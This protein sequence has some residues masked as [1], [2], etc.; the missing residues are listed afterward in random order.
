M[1]AGYIVLDYEQNDIEYY[2]TEQEAKEALQEVIDG[3]LEDGEWM[4]GVE[5]CFIAKITHV[6]KSRSHKTSEE[7]RLES[8][9]SEEYEMEIKDV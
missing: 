6:V 5:N 9:I 1:D 3:Y 7:Y 8:G 4:N 2:D